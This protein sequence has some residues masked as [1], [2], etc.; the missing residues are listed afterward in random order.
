MFK[1]LCLAATIAMSGVAANAAT[2]NPV[3]PQNDVLVTDVLGGGWSI[4]YQDLYSQNTDIDNIF[5]GAGSM[6]M[7]A[8]RQVGADRFDLLATVS[9]ALF[10]PL[11]TAP[12]ATVLS[13]GSE[14]YK[15]GFSM[16]FANAGDPITQNSADTN[17]TGNTDQRMSWHTNFTGW[18]PGQNINDPAEWLSNG[19]RTGT[20]TGL[21]FDS[22]WERFVLTKDA[23]PAIPV[24][25]ALPLL[26]GA[27]GT[28]AFL[29][30]R[31]T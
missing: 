31:P 20:N 11:Q 28:F 21:N 12:N 7:L 9:S 24:P 4:I 5:A 6:I 13:N 17:G 2:Y 3:G 22:G 14:W 16:G 25:A 19:W 1:K 26:I 29:R 30:R 8:S 18:A 23:V 27:L 10:I 15:N